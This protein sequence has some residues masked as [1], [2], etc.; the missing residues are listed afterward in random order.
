MKIEVLLTETEI[1]Q[2]FSE[3][4]EARDL[5]EKFFYWSPLSVDAW[6]AVSRDVAYE[7]HLHSWNLLVGDI[8][9]IAGRYESA[10]AVVSL[11]AG[12]GGKDVLLLK[13][14]DKA[15]LDVEYFPVDASQALLELACAAAE[16]AEIDTLG[17][18]ADISSPMHLLLASDA[19][20]QPKLFLLT[21][22]TLGGLD[23]LDQVRHIAHCMHEK[24]CLIVDAEIQDGSALPSRDNPPGRRF[25]FSPLASLGLTREDGDVRFELKRDDRHEGLHLITRHFHAA[26]DLN[27][28][29]P[30]REI[31][32]QRGERVSL[33]F[34]YTYSPDAFRWLLTTHGRLQILEEVSSPD[35]RFMT[36]LCS[37]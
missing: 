23:P 28:A 18:K 22:S 6:L 10:V 33:N 11:G 2:E 15:S 9:K 21:G 16:D 7:S 31:M 25:A 29:A 1:C 35:G 26:R 3:A 12:D 36:A 20:E 27:I 8:E 13:A 37:R 32:L 17:M 5:P 30:Q 4:L 24:D 34:N 19:S 14:L